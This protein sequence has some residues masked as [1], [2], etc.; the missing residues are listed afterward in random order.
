MGLE[1]RDDTGYRVCVPVCQ[2]SGGSEV[3]ETVMKKALERCAEY[4]TVENGKVRVSDVFLKPKVE[5]YNYDFFAGISCEFDLRRPV[6]DRVTK[7][8]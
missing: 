7:L 4:F 1:K 8:V 5:H 6:G 2:H 3:D